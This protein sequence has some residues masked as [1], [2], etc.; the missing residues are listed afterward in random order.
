ML[1]QQLTA[2]LLMDLQ[3]GL[4]SIQ[5]QDPI[6]LP[7]S[8]NTST[9]CNCKYFKDWCW[10]S[11]INNTIFFT[12][13]TYFFST[14]S[15]YIK[16]IQHNSKFHLHIWNFCLIKNISYIICKVLSSDEGGNFQ[17]HHVLRLCASSVAQAH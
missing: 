3:L 14:E 5:S 8:K 15:V 6:L 10:C 13:R 4:M 7:T 17:P 16:C 2:T 11:Y 9:T 1:R 12:G